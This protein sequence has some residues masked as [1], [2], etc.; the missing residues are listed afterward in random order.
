M[1]TIFRYA[2]LLM[3]TYFVINWMADNPGKLELIRTEVNS[4]VAV[5]ATVVANTINEMQQ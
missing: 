3:G 2:L 1:N 4:A 5:S